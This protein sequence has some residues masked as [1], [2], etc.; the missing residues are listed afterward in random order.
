MNSPSFVRDVKDEADTDTWATDVALAVFEKTRP[1]ILLIN[2]PAID[3]AGHASGGINAP[4]SMGPVIANADKQIGRIIDAYQQAGVYGQTVFVVI[5]DHGMTPVTRTI[6]QAAIDRICIESGN[7]AASFGA[8]IGLVNPENA[9][10]VAEKIETARLPGIHGAYYKVKSADGS[11]SYEPAGATA[12]SLTGDVDK[13]Y[14]YLLST[15]AS[16]KSMV[17]ELIPAENWHVELKTGTGKP[18]IGNHDS[19]TWLQQHNIL[20]I[21]GPG[22]NR[23]TA[24][25]SPARL[26]DVAPTVL[27]LMGITPEK[28]DGTVLADALQSPSETQVRAQSSANGE[29][30]P[31]V[32][33]L[34]ALSESDLAELQGK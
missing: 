18:F 26:A 34:K 4:E 12:A 13:A 2:L 24:S 3:D 9:K 29:L 32:E 33:A 5:S 8:A 1:E 15:W 31:L 14:R 17:I 21:A 28:M 7:F 30:M 16:E 10:A 6:S 22:V 23:G 25:Q 27:T 20:L 19:P 11:Y